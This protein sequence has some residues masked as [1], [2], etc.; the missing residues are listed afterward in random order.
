MAEDRIALEVGPY[1]VETWTPEPGVRQQAV[2][3]VHG[4]TTNLRVQSDRLRQSIHLPGARVGL[5][6]R[7]EGDSF[8][9]VQA[10]V[11][12]VDVLD[13]GEHDVGGAAWQSF[14]IHPDLDPADRYPALLHDE[15]PYVEILR[16]RPRLNLVC[17]QQHLGLSTPRVLDVSAVEEALARG[18]TPFE[19]QILVV[20]NDGIIL[21]ESVV[22]FVVPYA[23][24]GTSNLL[25][26]GM[27]SETPEHLFG[28]GV[29]Q[30]FGHGV[31][32]LEQASVVHQRGETD[33]WRFFVVPTRPIWDKF[34]T[35]VAAGLP[36]DLVGSWCYAREPGF[37]PTRLPLDPRDPAAALTALA[38][39]SVN[40]DL[41]TEVLRHP[42][43]LLW[44]S[45]SKQESV[46]VNM[47]AEAL[48]LDFLP[49]AKLYTLFERIESSE[50]AGGADTPLGLI[51]A[52]CQQAVDDAPAVLEHLGLSGL[53]A[54]DGVAFMQQKT[55]ALF[56]GVGLYVTSGANADVPEQHVRAD[57][58]PL[59]HMWA[60]KT[61]PLTREA[62]RERLWTVLPEAIA[63]RRSSFT[64]VTLMSL[65][66][67]YYVFRREAV[68]A[69]R[70][71]AAACPDELILVAVETE[72]GL[73]ALLD[74]DKPA[75]LLGIG[76]R[77]DLADLL[78]GVDCYLCRG[79]NV[80]SLFDGVLAGVPVVM[81]PPDAITAAMSDKLAELNALPE[82]DR[83]GVYQV[84]RETVVERTAMMLEAATWIARSGVDPNASV[85]EV[86]DLPD[87][88]HTRAVMDAATRD[89]ALVSEALRGIPSARID[90]LV[91]LLDHLRRRGDVAGL[92]ALAEPLF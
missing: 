55:E 64:R 87:A 8:V 42:R 23:L 7:R 49:T 72:D 34:Q 89:Q 18:M 74:G 40:Q 73:R 11:N 92:R 20:P 86:T 9:L 30:I 25:E 16:A 53:P 84:Q 43:G 28:V 81:L 4:W 50:G 66:S 48:R 59:P 44:Y 37:G 79:G 54:A 36:E 90:D 61:S 76:W 39:F 38:F 69:V 91:A 17:P 80:G 21:P 83:I 22:G 60:A 13:E 35:L 51:G 15:A 52:R 70:T 5:R 88:D 75:N 26:A 12:R 1:R 24:D 57:I 10:R 77:N 78:A 82:P 6:F 58:V 68:L 47:L 45:D 32:L 41:L 14:G 27:E 65:G 19:F 62:A 63:A 2:S 71:L 31:G 29:A 67:S 33:C 85:L 3:S 56:G 46:F